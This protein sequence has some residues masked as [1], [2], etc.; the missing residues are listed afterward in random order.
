MGLL[1]DRRERSIDGQAGS[2]GTCWA[3]QELRN[4]SSDFGLLETGPC[5]LFC[6]VWTDTAATSPGV[7]E[8]M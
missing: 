7:Q 1:A 2:C 4:V 8:E 3:Q 6:K 5:F